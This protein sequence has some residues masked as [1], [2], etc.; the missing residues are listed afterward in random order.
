MG[1]QFGQTLSGNIILERRFPHVLSVAIQ[2]DTATEY[3]I[4]TAE[5]ALGE[6]SVKMP[7]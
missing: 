5:S 1:V 4:K 3:T 6:I 7:L 2:E